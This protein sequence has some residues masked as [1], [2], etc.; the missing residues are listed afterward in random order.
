[1]VY[2]R[3]HE[4]KY[5]LHGEEGLYPPLCP[6]RHLLVFHDSGQLVGLLS[7]GQVNPFGLAVFIAL[8]RHEYV[9]AKSSDHRYVVLVPC[10]LLVPRQWKVLLDA[11]C[12]P[13]D[14]AYPTD[15]SLLHEARE[16]LEHIIDVLYAP[17]PWNF[18]QTL[19]LLQQG[20]AG[21]FLIITKQRRANKKKLR[22]G[23]GRTHTRLT[24]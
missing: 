3:L 18:V 9:A 16:K 2:P 7:K 6:Y 22:K 21:F 1:M 14:I 4:A 23:V 24:Y 11:T 8:L 20:K 10:L 12:A 15:L 19:N 17:P 5:I 13:A